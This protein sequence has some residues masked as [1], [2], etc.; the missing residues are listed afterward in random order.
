MCISFKV[1]HIDLYYGISQ[2]S[3]EKLLIAEDNDHHRD[4]LLAK[5]PKIR[6]YRKFALN[7]TCIPHLLYHS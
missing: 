4:P 6:S 5:D 7:G 1:T 2:L 3:S